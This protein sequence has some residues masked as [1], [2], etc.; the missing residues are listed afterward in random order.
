MRKNSP[1]KSKTSK[2]KK[3]IPLGVQ[4]KR[5]YKEYKVVLWISLCVFLA[6]YMKLAEEG[7]FTRNRS[8]D[9][10]YDIMGLTSKATIK[11]IK[12]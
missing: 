3:T 6:F 9:D 2:P 12:K 5:F 8:Q 11:D 1:R 10:L 4:L 7:G